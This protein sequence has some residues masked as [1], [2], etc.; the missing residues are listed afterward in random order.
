MS[1]AHL[2]QEVDSLSSVK[3]NQK[4]W[5]FTTVR[6]ASQDRIS[7]KSRFVLEQPLLAVRQVGRRFSRYWLQLAGHLVPRHLTAFCPLPLHATILKPHLHLYNTT[8]VRLLSHHS[9]L[10]HLER[11]RKAADII[12][13]NA[14]DINVERYRTCVGAVPLYKL[15]AE[16]QRT[17]KCNA[18]RARKK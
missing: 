3:F 6:L 11:V 15:T 14:C 18:Y 8:T 10:Q 17:Y 16:V 2:C 5:S 4:C 12:K 9:F 1:R 13:Q 7:R